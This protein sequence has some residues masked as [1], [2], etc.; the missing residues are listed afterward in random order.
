ML[1]NCGVGEDS[2]ESVGLQ[3]DPTNPSWRRS[4]LNI[5][6][7]DWCWSWN[8]SILATWCKELTHLKRLWCWERLKGIGESSNRMRWL[9]GITDLMDMSL[10]KL[11][12]LVMDREAWRTTVHGVAKSWTWLS[13]WTEL[14]YTGILLSHKKEWIWVSSSEVDET[15]ACYTEWTQK[16]KNEYCILTYKYTI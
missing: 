6:W 11:W 3:G 15:R 1:L 14:I 9:D 16:E 4:V 5:H 13:D 7:N 12:D 10:S 8:S 2:W